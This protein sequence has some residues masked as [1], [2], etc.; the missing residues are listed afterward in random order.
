V[1]PVAGA[2]WPVFAIIFAQFTDTFGN[3]DAG[4][5]F[6]D[7]VALLATYFVYLGVGSLVCSYLE[8]AMWMWTGNRQTN[9]IKELYLK[10]VL[11]QDVPFF[12][13][14]STTGG[15]LA[16]LSEDSIAIQQATSEKVRRVACGG[17]SG[18]HAGDPPS[19][20]LLLQ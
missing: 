10:A 16:G 7:Q 19:E 6:S 11:R 4:S 5:S 17:V 13:V 1:P 3:P 15:L 9:R 2:A 20:G 12:D 8:A 18:G 14:H